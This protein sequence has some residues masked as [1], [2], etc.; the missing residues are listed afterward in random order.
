MQLK[1][2]K[3]LCFLG[4]TFHIPLSSRYKNYWSKIARR[5]EEL[6]SSR[7]HF[8]VICAMPLLLGVRSCTIGVTVRLGCDAASLN[9]RRPTFRESIVVLSSKIKTSNEGLFIV[10]FDPYRWDQNA[11]SKGR[12]PIIQWRGIASGKNGDCS[13]EN[14]PKL[15]IWL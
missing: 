9:D 12:A 6:T 11:V 15:F 2:T 4:N 8:C 3:V 5:Q 13:H 10:Q 1:N 7:A 14:K